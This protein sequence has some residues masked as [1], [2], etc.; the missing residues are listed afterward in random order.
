MGLPG[1]TLFTVSSLWKD[2]FRNIFGEATATPESIPGARRSRT[3]ENNHQKVGSSS[4]IARRSNGAE[5]FFAA[6]QGTEGLSILDLGGASQANISF[7]TD[8][9]HRLSSDD[10]AG[11][12]DQCFGDGDF[13][14]YQ[15][16]ASR[17]QRFFDQ[18]LNFPEGYFDGALVW[19]TLQFLAPG[20]FEQTVER[21]LRIV[22]PGGLI[23]AFFSS[24]E[25]ATQI[26][27]YNYRIQ[28]QKTLLLVPRGTFRQ[29]QYFNNRTLE[30][31]FQQAQSVK[32]FLTRDH[33]REIIVRR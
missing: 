14:E 31:F 30:R 20:L 3:H 15:G 27:V 32:F 10:I 17:V 26:P 13:F 11:T 8:L 19:D 21:I 22:K 4:T 28:D 18:S 6:L 24:D 12:M 33:L 1:H 29:I 7:I 5:Q 23:L 9:G 16:A 25:K 2:R